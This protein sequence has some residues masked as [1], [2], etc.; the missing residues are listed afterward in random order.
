ME[1]KVRLANYITCWT[2]SHI[3]I[4]HKRINYN[5]VSKIHSGLP[6]RRGE[7]TRP[8]RHTGA[9]K[10]LEMSHLLC[11]FKGSCV[12]PQSHSRF[13]LLY[14]LYTGKHNGTF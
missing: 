14:I 2:R 1:L 13:Y 3:P 8:G 10:A 11:F 9:S 5:T 7:G 4:L 6:L 12:P